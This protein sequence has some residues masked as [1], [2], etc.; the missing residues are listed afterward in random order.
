MD[1]LKANTDQVIHSHRVMQALHSVLSLVRG[2]ESE[3]RGYGLSGDPNFLGTKQRAIDSLRSEIQQLGILSAN[4]PYDHSQLTQLKQFV[5][6]RM[7][8]LDESVEARK[9]SGLQGAVKKIQSGEGTAVMERIGAI[10]GEMDRRE[11]TLLLEESD[12]AAASLRNTGWVFLAGNGL[13]LLLLAFMFTLAAREIKQRLRAQ[14]DLRESESKNRKL[15]ETTNDIVDRNDDEIRQSEARYR[16]LAENATDVIS[17]LTPEGIYLYVSPSCKRVLGYEPEELLGRSAYELLHPDDYARAR[18]ARAKTK[19]VPEIVTNSHRIRM[20]SGAYIWFEST[21]KSVKDPL[22]E[23]VIEIVTISRDITV[24]KSIEESLTESERRLEQIIE[25]VQ[26]GITLSDK[27]GRYDIFN[28][29]MEQLTGYTM[30]EA[31]ASGDFSRVLY[32]HEDNRTQTLDDLKILLEKGQSTEVE[33]TI[34]TKQ[35]ESRTLLVSTSLVVFRNQAMFLSAYRDVTERKKAEQELKG[36]KEAAEAATRAK[37]EFLAVMSH[38]IRTPMNSVI[39]MTDLLSHSTLTN[40]QRDFVD[41]IRGSGESL[42]TI[43]NDI[44]DFSKIESGKLD[45]EERPC[46]PRTCVEAVLDLLTPNAIQKGLDLLYW[47]DPQVP[48]YIIGDAHRLRQ[49]LINLGGNAVKF[50]DRGDVFVSVNLL[51]KLG[52]KLELQFSVRDSGMGIPADKLDRLF[53]PFSQVDTSTTRKFGGTGLGLAISMRLVQ[54]MGGKIWAESEEG[55]GSTF[56]FTMKTSTPPPDS[57]LPKVHTRAKVPELTG[58]RVLVVDDNATNLFILRSHCEN[59]GMLVRTTQSPREAIHWVRIGDPFDV[60]IL[61]MMIPEMDGHRLAHELRSIRTRESLPLVLLSSAGVSTTEIGAGDLFSA[62]VAKPVKHDLLFDILMESMGGAKRSS[63]RSKPKPVERLGERISLSILAAE[64]NP[65][66]QKLLLRVLKEIGYQADIVPNGVEVMSAV[67]AK[68]YDIIFM[69]V[70]MPEMD[71]LEASRLINSIVPRDERPVIV[72][73]TAGAL[74]GDRE[75][76]MQ[77]GMDDYITKPIHIADIESVLQRWTSKA[78]GRAAQEPVSS[79]LP[80]GEELE[81]AMSDRISQ[82]GLETDPAFVVELID[83]Y[84]PLFRNQSRAIDEACGKRDEA[85]LRYAAHSLKGASLN[86]GAKKLGA[87]CKSMED[88][89]EHGDIDSAA[90]LIPQLLQVIERTSVALGMIKTRLSKEIQSGSGND[91]KG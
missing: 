69:D 39:G 90:K 61:D 10:I 23:R 70:H 84:A 40:E 64:D 63:S 80:T 79:E 87:I 38:D 43:I 78:A 53:K 72:A 83:S 13:G 6:E 81:A 88:F 19:E 50:T 32:F 68:R 29:A 5:N 52:D 89:A 21:T 12:Q 37:S 91:S 4:D 74:E 82:L 30:A 25:T 45:L 27:N 2:A 48:P 67:K 20:K 3:A 58:K 1:Q 35:G 62:A 7:L 31:N 49:I 34:Q 65:V 22:D 51:W 33:T 76:C 77:A 41:T 54:F 11:H 55:K 16:I 56:F 15:V 73:V 8:L 14:D 28:S 57:V 42:L 47:I 75:K 17:R 44:L 46:E 66:N 36:A 60:G 26:E 59:W 71:G 9:I 86:I 24:R 85:K 18:I